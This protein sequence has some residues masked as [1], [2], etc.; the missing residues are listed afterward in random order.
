MRKKYKFV[1]ILLV[2][3]IITACGRTGPLIPYEGYVP[4]FETPDNMIITQ[5]S[6]DRLTD[7]E[8]ILKAIDL[9]Y[10]D[11]I[12]FDEAQA[13]DY[14][15]PSYQKKLINREELIVIILN[16]SSDIQTDSNSKSS[17][18]LTDLSYIDNLT[19][20]ELILK[21]I[22]LGYFDK[23]EFDEAQAQD[24]D[25]PSY[26]KKLINRDELVTILK[27]SKSLDSRSD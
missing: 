22:D 16:P 8:L 13:Q 17:N 2:P 5:K 14:D 12:E 4:S 6:L 18:T 24:Y 25:I 9:G 19:D 3:L 23:I 21:A 26:Q 11:K 20:S 10:F 7:P 27:V 15:I 1:L